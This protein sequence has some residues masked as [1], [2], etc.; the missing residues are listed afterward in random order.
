MSEAEPRAVDQDEGQTVGHRGEQI[1]QQRNHGGHPYQHHQH[2]H[3]A[4]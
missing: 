1:L 3:R 2:G 4:S